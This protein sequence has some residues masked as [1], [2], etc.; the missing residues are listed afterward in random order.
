MAFFL[1]LTTFTLILLLQAPQPVAEFFE[2]KGFA[3][4]T[5]EQREFRFWLLLFPLGHMAIA[6][7]VE[8]REFL[9]SEVTST[10]FL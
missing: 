8:V 7:V 2:V 1:S 6:L 4:D 5:T 9:S 3:G 10:D